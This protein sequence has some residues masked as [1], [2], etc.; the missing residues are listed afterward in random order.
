MTVIWKHKFAREEAFRGMCC[1]IGSLK[2]SAVCIS[3]LE[4]KACPWLLEV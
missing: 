1:Y 4:A 2:V 3:D